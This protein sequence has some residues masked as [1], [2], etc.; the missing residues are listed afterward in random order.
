MYKE[1]EI[2]N[3]GT[4]QPLFGTSP[5]DGEFWTG[6]GWWPVQ[7]PVA[8]PIKDKIQFPE[9]Y[10]ILLRIIWA[11]CEKL[12]SKIKWLLGKIISI[13]AELFMERTN[14]VFIDFE[15]LQTN[16]S[17]LMGR[18]CSVYRI[19]LAGWFRALPDVGYSLFSY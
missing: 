17:P 19:G 14:I 11:I 13:K 15:G 1:K 7:D 3:G 16:E 18:C 9:K 8:D 6:T 4:F 2:L 5:F 10:L 12:F